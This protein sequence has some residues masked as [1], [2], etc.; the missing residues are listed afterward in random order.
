[1]L[2]PIHLVRRVGLAAASLAVLMAPL[3]PSPAAL[4]Q[5]PERPSAGKSV[6]VGLGVY[7]VAVSPSTNTVYVAAAGS[8]AEPAAAVYALDADSLDVKSKIDVS[9]AAAYGLGIND[10][11]QTLYTTN[12][13]DGSVSAI[14]LRS[15]KVIG[16]IKS[17][18][19][20]D[21]HM[22]E[23]V[24]DESTEHNLRLELRRAGHDLGY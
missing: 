1:M 18:V 14:D 3:I 16:T 15:N 22:R 6:R 8:R 13:R 9:K 7:E 21:A 2:N 5:A 12:T 10:R 20:K 23:V 11:T 19:D 24:V 4:A 17:D